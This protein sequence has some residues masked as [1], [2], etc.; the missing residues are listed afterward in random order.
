MTREL[1]FPA[2]VRTHVDPAD[3]ICVSGLV[4]QLNRG[5]MELL[6]VY[7]LQGRVYAVAEWRNQPDLTPHDVDI[8]RYEG[9][10]LTHVGQTMGAY[11]ETQWFEP[12]AA[13]DHS[14]TEGR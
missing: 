2:T 8:Y 13:K 10:A 14:T 12:T 6:D 11:G 4:T 1:S 3:V 9:E 7:G 5:R